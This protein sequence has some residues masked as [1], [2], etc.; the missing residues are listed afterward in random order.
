MLKSLRAYAVLAGGAL[1]LLLSAAPSQAQMGLVVQPRVFNDFP[2]SNATVAI[3]A[4]PAVPTPVPTPAGNIGVPGL[5]HSVH[6]HDTNMVN[7][8]GGGFANRNDIL[9]SQNN[10]LSAYQGDI[11]TGF[12]ISANVTLDAG[13]SAPRKEAGLRVNAP[14]TGDCL[15][16][17]N[18]DA[19][20][21]VAFGGGAPFYNFR[22]A[23]EPAYIPGQTIFMQMQYVPGVPTTTGATPGTMQYWAQLLPAGPLLTSGPLPFSNLE[24]GPGGIGNYTVG[25]Y[26][27][28]TPV[29]GNANDFIDA[30]FGNIQATVPEPASLGL[31]SLA[32]LGLMARRRNA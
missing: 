26:D 21:I 19:G 12:T 23:I 31:L 25:F 6:L 13:V 2:G 10:G 28:G 15:F 30:Q 14:V 7:A 3:D 1:G 5:P 22:P 8:G 16:I 27:Q 17:L 4:G 32:G 24:G 9:I 11:N 18:T 20:E 29:S